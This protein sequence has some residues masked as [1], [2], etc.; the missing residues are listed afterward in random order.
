M[1]P[2][3]DG[4]VEFFVQLLTSMKIKP[5]KAREYSEGLVAQGYDEELF[6]DESIEALQTDFKFLKGD[7]KRVEKHRKGQA[8]PASGG[9]SA[10]AAAAAQTPPSSPHGRSARAPAGNLLDPARSNIVTEEKLGSGGFADVHPGEYRFPGDE[11]GTAVAFKVFRGAPDAKLYKQITDEAQVGAKV[12]RH[13]NL[14]ELHGVLEVDER[15]A[16]VL[17][18]A[19]GGSLRDLLDNAE[20]ELAWA[21]RVWLLLG[22]AEGVAELHSHKPAIIHRDLKGD[23]VLLSEDLQT[24]KVADFGIAKAAETM[25]STMATA[26]VKGSTSQASSPPLAPAPRNPVPPRALHIHSRSAAARHFPDAALGAQAAERCRGK[27]RRLSKI[28]SA[29]RRTCLPS[30]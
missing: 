23:N 20:R 7:A 19:A 1:E 22:I 27:P 14:V 15:V 10:G 21:L 4:T 9:G 16:L 3:A 8:T 2:A 25:R 29:P 30:A 5:D 17:E 13:P 28:N 11:H 12:G 18:H 26:D 24:A 6:G